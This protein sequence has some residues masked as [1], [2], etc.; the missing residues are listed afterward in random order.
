MNEVASTIC[1]TICIRYLHIV[2]FEVASTICETICIRYLHIVN[3]EVASTI[4]E[5]ICIRYLVMSSPCFITYFILLRFILLEAGIMLSKCSCNN[6]DY[7]NNLTS[8]APRHIPVTVNILKFRTLAACQK[9]L[10]KQYSRRSDCFRRSSLISVFPL[11]CSN[12]HFVNF[13][14]Q[15]KHFI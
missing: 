6:I 14:P 12:K 5:T 7:Y 13:S 1:E 11:C 3:Y 15:N 10:D 9:G 8:S 4:C 2:N